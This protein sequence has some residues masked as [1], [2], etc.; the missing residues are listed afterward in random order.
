MKV[1]EVEEKITTRIAGLE[2]QET[3]LHEW[4]E[5]IRQ[6]GD[7]AEKMGYNRP[8]SQGDEGSLMKAFEEMVEQSGVDDTPLLS[9]GLS[10][11][12]RDEE[13]AEKQLEPVE[14]G[15]AHHDQE[16][17]EDSVIVGAVPERSEEG[18]EEI[19]EPFESSGPRND[20]NED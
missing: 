7:I 12:T 15:E 2:N 17:K 14:P 13:V 16:Q 8:K 9:A 18:P 10:V 1:Q 11:E 4:L 5:C 20:Q 19:Q 6:V 3:R